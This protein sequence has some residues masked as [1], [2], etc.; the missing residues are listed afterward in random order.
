MIVRKARIALKQ[1]SKSRYE[2]IMY[3]T[4]KG[5][6]K[7]GRCAGEARLVFENK[8]LASVNQWS[9]F[10]HLPSYPSPFPSRTLNARKPIILPSVWRAPIFHSCEMLRTL[11]KESPLLEASC[12]NGRS[13]QILITGKTFG[14]TTDTCKH[15]L[16]AVVAE[17]VRPLLHENA[18]RKK[19]KHR[20]I[21]ENFLLLL[22][23]T[24]RCMYSSLSF[25]SVSCEEKVLV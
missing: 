7:S 17:E 3:S 19:G 24:V 9:S 22:A 10:S 20:A 23:C 6:S 15:Y 25:V 14:V 4:S 5:L 21:E 16:P 18:K 12:D 11:M 13:S 2:L 8:C 1:G